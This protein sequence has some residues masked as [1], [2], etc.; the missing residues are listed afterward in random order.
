[1]SDKIHP[2]CLLCGETVL[3]KLNAFKDAGLV[4]CTKCHFVFSAF[5]PD[6]KDLTSHY[7][8]YPRGQGTSPITLRRF[9]E[10]SD[11]LRKY[12]TS[13]K[14]I[15]V[16]CG[17]GELLAQLKLKGWN[18]FGTEFSESA[19]LLCE[20]KGI[21]MKKGP[22][23][24]ADFEENS[25]DVISS[26]EVLEHINNPHE[27]IGNFRK[28]LRTGGAVYINTPN[29]NSF[30]RHILGSK[31]SIIEYPEHLCYYTTKS[32]HK[33]LTDHRFKKVYLTTS[34]FNPSRFLRPFHNKQNQSTT[35]TASSK[36]ELENLRSFT[37]YNIVGAMAKKSINR[38]LHYTGTGD[39]VKAL[40]IKA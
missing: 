1:M 28:L 22:L 17:S 13:G 8:N 34:G 36:S 40:Y 29:F 15:D 33:L 10:L 30:S 19:V 27:E 7:D 39:T 11:Q 25:F 35:A 3:K 14:W 9:S 4:R 12:A 20:S 26:I 6:L 18:V 31:W 21:S 24:A 2:E 37:E 32:L 16:G 38:L 23:N 5:I